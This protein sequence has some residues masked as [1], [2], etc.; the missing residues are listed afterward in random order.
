MAR[1]LLLDT[2]SLFFRAFFALPPMTTTGGKP[3]S[4]LYGFSVLLLKLIRE[5]QPLGLA[6]ALDAPQATFRHTASPTYKAQRATAPDS[7][8]QQLAVLPRLL[9]AVGAPTV[10]APGFEADDVL[11]TQARVLTAQG[12]AVR[13]VTGDRDLFQ[14]VG[15]SVDVLFLGARGQKPVVCDLDA[16]VRR[17]GLAPEQLPLRTALVGDVA[18]NLP[19]V[20]GVGDKTAERLARRFGDAATLLARLDEVTPVA[21]REALRAAA[22]QIG[23]TEQLAR[24]RYDV[25]LPEGPL[26]SALDADAIARIRS[27]FVEL[28]FGSLLPRLDRLSEEALPGGAGDS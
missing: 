22:A 12:R 16:I 9:E 21:L 7:L 5:E 8:R 2:Y 24:L 28:E 6:F 18:D 15:P 27:L 4:A 14:V 25:P 17:Y 10:V 11:A 13:I 3:T 23:E 26:F 1:V 19:K 20:P